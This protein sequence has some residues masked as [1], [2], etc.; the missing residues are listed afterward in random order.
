MGKIKYK[1][2]VIIENIRLLP[3]K[4]SHHI[5]L[6]A[7]IQ[8]SDINVNS[9]IF[10]GCKFYRSSIGKWSYVGANSFVSDANIGSFTSISTDCYIGGAAH[11]LDRVSSSYHFY[12]TEKNEDG[13]SFPFTRRY[14]D[15]FSKTKIGNDVW[16][17]NRVIIKAGVSI[18]DGAVIGMGSVV[19]HD[20]GPYEIWAGN[21][22]RLIRK[23]FDDETIK[24]LLS[25]AWWEWSDEEIIKYSKFFD[26][27]D[28]LIDRV[29]K[30]K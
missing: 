4:L 13:L 10:A 24:S 25:L 2:G 19:T 15:A 5:S 28:L 30:I 7:I 12:C 3:F 29:G 18:S 16:I 8:K 26:T 1:L 22:A 23:R 6:S 20:V 14:F 11:P 9:R 21:P 27:P 17:G